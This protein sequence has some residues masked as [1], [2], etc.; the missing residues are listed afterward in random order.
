[1]KLSAVKLM[2]LALLL[3]GVAGA[4]SALDTT[5]ATTA[6]CDGYTYATPPVKPARKDTTRTKAPKNHRKGEK[7][8]R[9]APQDT[10]KKAE[11]TTL[12]LNAA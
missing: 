12:G 4:A 9:Q 6:A 7:P 1:M 2:L 8:K 3:T 11:N 5:T 10:I